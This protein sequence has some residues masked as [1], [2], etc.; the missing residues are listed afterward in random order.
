[1]KYTLYFS[2][3][4][5]LII[6]CTKELP[7]PDLE[8]QDY[9]VVNGLISP[10]TGVNIHLSQSCHITDVQCGQKSIKDGQVF[11]KDET[12]KTLTQLTHT[13]DGMYTPW[14]YQIEHDKIYTIEASSAGMESIFSKTNTPKL[15]S[16]TLMGFDEKIY[17]GFLCRTFEIE[18]ED[19]PDETNYYLINGWINIL[20]G[21]HEEGLGYEVNGYNVPH[22]GFLTKDINA[23][24]RKMVSSTDIIPYPLDY[25]FLTDENFNGE[26]YQLEFGLFEEDLSYDKDF[27]LEAHIN[28]KSVSKDLFDYY[29][30]ISLY[31]LTAGNALSEPEQIFSN[32]EKG[33]GI[34]GGF[35]Q[36][37]L[38]VDLPK[39]EFWFN[40]DF[41]VVNDGCTAPCTVK[42]FTE[43]GDKVNFTWDFGDGATSTEKNPE[44]EFQQPGEYNVIISITTGDGI[45]SSSKLITIN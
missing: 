31:K 22:T 3:L 28:V 21:R 1:M 36:Q 26:K 24:N 27:V 33:G 32:I 6:S 4:F 38:V 34:L 44:H 23:D 40:G 18:I 20:N 5:F 14:N 12:G 39:T 45:N 41:T 16:S 11:L 37:E 25:V 7:Y 43:I 17:E 2:S 29:K 8:N 35:T 19:N 30:S 15:F 9:L 10:E 13:G 42:F